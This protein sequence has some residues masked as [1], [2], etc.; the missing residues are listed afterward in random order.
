VAALGRVTRE[1]RDGVSRWRRERQGDR[2]AWAPGG[3]AR[4]S[5]AAGSDGARTPRRKREAEGGD[6]GA[7]LG[8]AS[9][10]WGALGG[11]AG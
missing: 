1:H 11:G 3:E 7:S 4:R 5:C 9:R 10:G 8:D 2:E 6:G